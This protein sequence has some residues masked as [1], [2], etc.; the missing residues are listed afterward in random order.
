M[1][2]YIEDTMHVRYLFRLRSKFNSGI[3][4]LPTR[5]SRMALQTMPSAC[6][7]GK[8]AS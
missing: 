5:I 4:A 1:I 8:S 2:S 7:A 6:T 3:D